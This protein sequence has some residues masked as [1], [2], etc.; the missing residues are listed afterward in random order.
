VKKKGREIREGTLKLN[1]N[2]KLEHKTVHFVEMIAPALP[3]F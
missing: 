2:Q 1:N 3:E